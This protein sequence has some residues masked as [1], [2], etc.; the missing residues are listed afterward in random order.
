RSL[1][2]KHFLHG[3]V[4]GA[5]LLLHERQRVGK[6]HLLEIVVDRSRRIEVQLERST[7]RIRVLGQPFRVWFGVLGGQT[8][9][10]PTYAGHIKVERSPVLQKRNFLVVTLQ[11]LAAFRDVVPRI[12]IVLLLLRIGRH[13][14]AQRFF[15]LRFLCDQRLVLQTFKLASKGLQTA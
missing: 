5:Q 2:R 12:A 11:S 3:R 10:R 15:S 7:A 8:N 14:S 13:G 1:T 4:I 9:Q 6:L